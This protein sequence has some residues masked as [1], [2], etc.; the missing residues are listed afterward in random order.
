M[1]KKE[2]VNGKMVR[3]IGDYFKEGKIRG[4]YEK[5][6]DKE[7][8]LWNYHRTYETIIK[9]LIKNGFEIIDY[10]DAF[11]K[12]GLK[13]LFPKEHELSS[14]VPNFCVWKVRKR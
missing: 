13:K 4:I 5:I 11:P 9:T 6:G 8:Q 2:K 12:K 3:I 14:K 10:K 7:I 1:G